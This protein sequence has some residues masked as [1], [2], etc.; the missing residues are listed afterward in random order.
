MYVNTYDYDQFVN[1][2]WFGGEDNAQVIATFGLCGEAGEFA[3]KMKKLYRGDQPPPSLESAAME[4]GDVLFYLT[5]SAHILGLNLDQ[6]MALNK[7]K[8]DSRIERGTWSG[9]GDD[10]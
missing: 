9:S 7:S 1:K 2:T 10:R 8:L 3:E 6:I 5:K 4:L